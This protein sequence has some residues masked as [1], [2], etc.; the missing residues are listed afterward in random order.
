VLVVAALAG[1]LVAW[2]AVFAAPDLAL[3]LQT[4]GGGLTPRQAQ[5]ELVAA[6]AQAA[7]PDAAD[8]LLLSAD[9]DDA[10]FVRYL[11]YP[12]DVRLAG[13]RQASAVRAALEALP[14]G[15]LVLVSAHAGRERLED[16]DALAGGAA[17]RLQEVARAG[18]EVA[19]YRVLR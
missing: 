10:A 14:A 9:A 19:V 7:A 12:A 13:T 11:V 16:V 18:A 1:V 17:P 6:Q 15:A 5:L 3:Q 2:S 4:V 8:V